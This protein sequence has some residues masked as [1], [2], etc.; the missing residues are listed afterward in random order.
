MREMAVK[1]EIDEHQYTIKP[2]VIA[3]DFITHSLT[4][5]Y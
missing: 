2:F 4:G 3:G 1:N 5:Q